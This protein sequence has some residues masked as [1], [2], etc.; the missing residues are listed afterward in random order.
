MSAQNRNKKHL[1]PL[2][3]ST[4][5]FLAPLSAKEKMVLEFIENK[6]LSFGI[7]PTYTEIKDHF[8]FASFNSVQNYLKQ[9]AAKEY[10]L[11]QPNQKRAIQIL[12]PSTHVQDDL[13]E[14]SNLRESLDS[15][16]LQT[17]D[18]GTLSLPLL[19]RI[20]AGLPI[21]RIEHDEFIEVPPSLVQGAK[22]AFA[23]KI[24]GE[25]MIEEGI[26]NGDIILVESRGFAQDGQIVV[27]SVDQESTVKKYYYRVPPQSES[28]QKMIEL[29]PAN[30]KMKSMWYPP[31]LVQ[32][33]GVVIG[34]IRYFKSN[35][36]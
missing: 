24:E 28:H 6:I 2:P 25:S 9:L 33:R 14:K 4:Q 12:H 11:V 13:I 36:K 21:E 7:S 23:L 16:L 26:F 18:A 17:V 15:K 32:I 5:K 31:H 20:A 3:N 29:R 27:A 1:K 34:L 30:A 22:N 35:S 8:G 10:I 19:G